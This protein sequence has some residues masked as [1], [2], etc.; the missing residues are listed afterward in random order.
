MLLTRATSYGRKTNPACILYTDCSVSLLNVESSP[1]VP[2]A[3]IRPK[4]H[5]A[6]APVRSSRPSK[7]AVLT[8]Y[9]QSAL[10]E[11]ATRVFGERGFECATMDMIARDADVAKGTVYLY[12][13]SKKSIY[14]AAL[15]GGLAALDDR[16][17]ARIDAAATFR[18]VISAFILARA[19]YFLERHDFFRMYVAAIAQQ[20]MDVKAR[21]SEFAALVDRQTRHLEAAVTRAIAR[22]EIRRVDPG[23]TALAIF[24]LTR[25]LVARRLGSDAGAD[26]ADDSAFLADLI[27]R[28]LAPDDSGRKAHRRPAT[29]KGKR[30]SR[31]EAR[32]RK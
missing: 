4:P 2:H 29:S 5:T 24:D 14:D 31:A 25:G 1:A 9:R 16:T 22:R 3:P 8:A 6:A 13:P 28:G 19:E 10:L 21:P 11:A 12:Y 18:D 27:W 23:A 15:N 30:Q 32:P 26:F 17:G 7:E 20:V